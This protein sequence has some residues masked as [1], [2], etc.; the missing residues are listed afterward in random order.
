MI[1]DERIGRIEEGRHVVDANGDELV[2]VLLKVKKGG[3]AAA[4]DDLLATIEPIEISK[5]LHQSHPRTFSSLVIQEETTKVYR[6]MDYYSILGVQQGAS[7]AEIKKAY[8]KLAHQYHPDKNPGDKS[9]EERFKQIAEAYSVLSD[10][11]K[12][13]E[14]ARSRQ[15]WGKGPTF[16][17]FVN[18]FGS[19]GFRQGQRFHRTHQSTKEK[20]PSSEYLDIT[21]SHK[22]GLKDAALGTKIDVSYS[23][24]KINYTGTAGDRIT[25][26]KDD[27][28]KEIA[29]NLN[30]KTLYLALKKE[31]ART[32]AKVRVA[33]MGHEDV[34]TR[35]NVW[36]N[37]EQLPLFGD[38]YVEIEI[39]MPDDVQLEGKHVVHTVG[40]PLYAVLAKDEKVRIETAFDK[41]YDAEITAPKSL[42]EMKF[43]LPGQ[44]IVGEDGRLGDYIVRFEVLTP[45]VK[46]LKKEERDKLL[47]LLKDI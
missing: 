28:P 6:Q 13:E 29:I 19:G 16:E 40:I 27:E 15:G 20:Q 12:R 17:D 30:L 5:L 23:R 39:E 46:S 45:K 35:R 38:L 2:V 33:K 26:T 1:G 18:G 44:G 14:D 22:V 47:E 25:F 4:N 43:T 3:A 24:K 37:I 41:K 8:R 31:G 21:L 36:G 10:P 34:Y 9:A 42:N 11:E 7:E 32:V